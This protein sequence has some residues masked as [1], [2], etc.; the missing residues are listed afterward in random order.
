MI[1]FSQAAQG[2]KSKAAD[3]Y[4]AAYDDEYEMRPSK[5]H[6]SRLQNSKTVEWSTKSFHFDENHQIWNCQGATTT[7]QRT[8][9]THENVFCTC[10]NRSFQGGYCK[11][12]ISLAS[13]AYHFINTQQGE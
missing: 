12:I 9:F 6:K 8:I 7:G 2:L 5:R 4:D 10:A 3:I 11:H 1:P 13:N